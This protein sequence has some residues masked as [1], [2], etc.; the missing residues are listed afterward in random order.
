[1]NSTKYMQTDSRWGNLG[2]PKKPYYIR[3]CGC[4]ECAIANIIIEMDA[5]KNYTPKTIQ[6]YCKQY[7]DP[8]GNGTYWSGIPKM[9]KHYGLTEVQEHQTMKPLWTEL[10]KG[11]RVAVLLMGSKKAGSKKVKW[12]SSGHFICAVGYKYK[13]N[14]HYLYV[15]DSY[16]NASN[17]NGWLTYEENLA[18]DVLKVWSGKLKVTEKEETP[19][20]PTTPYT[21]G[22]P[23]GT[24]KDGSKGDDV[25]QV[26]KF[27]NWCINAGLTV[28][29]ACGSKTV[30]AIK[31]Y[32]K[33]YGLSDDGVFGGKS[34]SKAKEIIA[35]YEPTPKP[36]PK[37]VEKTWSEKAVDWAKNIAN[38]NSWHYVSW[39]QKNDKTH[40]CPICHKHPVGKYHGWNCIGF[41]YSCLY[42]GAGI[43]VKHNNG[44]INNAKA[45]K[46]L[47]AKTD[48]KATKLVTDALGNTS[49][50][51]IRSKSGVAISKMKAGDI[52]LYFKGSTYQHTYFYIGDSKMIDCTSV[53]KEAN[54]IKQR[55]ALTPKVVIRYTGK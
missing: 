13:N 52:G 55:K 4:G 19:Y 44:V 10:A 45:E 8:H 15:K 12:T 24:V 46:I 5:F 51:V 39:V 30:S 49:F 38:D 32:Q 3:N 18:N 2:Y 34:K 28:D 1:M 36:T 17:R 54:Q 35:K 47:N 53:S 6:P 20:T 40:E 41:A 16:S 26:Q 31:K 9:M 14:K 25:K 33:Q 37:P 21:G 7:A 48:A 50:K 11:N 42:H 27:L 29:G 43:K 22:L 23:I